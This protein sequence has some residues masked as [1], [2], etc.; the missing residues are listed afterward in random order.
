[1]FDIP[2]AEILHYRGLYS[3]FITQS[4]SN[5]TLGSRDSTPLPRS[6]ILL[7]PTIRGL[8]LPALPDFSCDV[9]SFSSKRVTLNVIYLIEEWRNITS[10]KEMYINESPTGAA[11][12]RALL[13]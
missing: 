5:R 1:M 12:I 9:N 2:P 6:N 4:V 3:D 13:L 8:P 11:K 7:L 10:D